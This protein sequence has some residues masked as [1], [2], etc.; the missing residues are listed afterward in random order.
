MQT[1]PP[2]QRLFGL[3]RPFYFRSFRGLDGLPRL[4]D[5]SLALTAIDAEMRIDI[6]IYEFSAHEHLK[7]VTA[8][9]RS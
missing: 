8:K 5:E 3:L 2:L 6:I 7:P 9:I 4:N 1:I